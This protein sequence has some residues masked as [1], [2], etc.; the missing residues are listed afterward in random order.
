MSSDVFS[1][2]KCKSVMYCL[3]YDEPAVI[4]KV[5]NIFLICGLILDY[6][7]T[8]WCENVFLTGFLLMN[9]LLFC[10]DYLQAQGRL[11]AI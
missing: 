11:A 10:A 1:V 8:V 2:L 4:G 3:E 9:D 6:H 7:I 5:S